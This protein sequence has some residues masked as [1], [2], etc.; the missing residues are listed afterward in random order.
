MSLA[1][2]EA[3]PDRVYSDRAPAGERGRAAAP[4]VLYTIV[5]AF[6]DSLRQLCMEQ[7]ESLGPAGG[8]DATPFI[9]PPDS[10]SQERQPPSPPIIEARDDPDTDS[11]SS[12]GLADD[13]V[14]PEGSEG[15]GGPRPGLPAESSPQ[16]PS[17]PEE[18]AAVDAT[19]SLVAGGPAP[20]TESQGNQPLQP[21]GAQLS[22][23]KVAP[24]PLAP[25]AAAALLG[26][27][28][29]QA[30]NA[31]LSFATAILSIA[32][33]MAWLQR[34]SFTPFVIY[35][36]ILGMALLGYAYGWFKY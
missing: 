16:A 18:E 31:G 30:G 26:R 19:A 9:P 12:E 27:L 7:V 23:Q 34:A 20:P 24:P 21:P 10:A 5:M 25:S 4:E 32:A 22:H 14:D 36:V 13:T 3:G 11:Q 17:H 2:Q 15:A 29:R 8:A 28:L 6:E 35:R 1:R 33:L